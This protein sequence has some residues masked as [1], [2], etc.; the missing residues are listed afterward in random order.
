MTATVLRIRACLSCSH[1]IC[2]FFVPDVKKG[3]FLFY[4]SCHTFTYT[5][6]N[7]QKLRDPGSI[8]SSYLWRMR[9]PRSIS[10]SY[11]GP[12]CLSDY[13]ENKI[14][15]WPKRQ[16]SYRSVLQFSLARLVFLLFWFTFPDSNIFAG[17]ASRILWFIW[18]PSQKQPWPV[19]SISA[20]GLFLLSEHAWPT[21]V[22]PPLTSCHKFVWS[23]LCYQKHCTI[24]STNGK[25]TFHLIRYTYVSG[26]YAM[27]TSF[28]CRPVLGFSLEIFWIFCCRTPINRTHI[29]AARIRVPWRPIPCEHVFRSSTTNTLSA[30]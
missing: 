9:D 26:T 1:S 27:N 25:W 12:F 28:T 5:F 14:K 11:C 21:R 6:R 16:A 30:L 24:P 2:N 3:C 23:S 22:A 17:T 10:S 18:Q 20:V 8:S 19:S 15:C 29:Y 4:F 7:Q 13:P